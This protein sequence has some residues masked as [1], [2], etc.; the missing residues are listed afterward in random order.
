MDLGI[1]TV[2]YN[3]RD[4]LA[5]CLNS[6][7]VGLE[8]SGLE[9]ETWVVDNASS[10]GSA[11]MVRQCFP[12]VRIVAHDQNLGFAAG[13]NLALRMM[14]FG[15][16]GHPPD[17]ATPRHI[18]F[19]NPD[20][21]VIGDAL[22]VMVHFLD[23]SPRAGAAGAR[24]TYGDG[25]FQHS[26]FAF[27]GLAQVFF[28]FFPL[29][30]RLLESRLN[31]RYPRRQYEQGR[32]FPVDHPLGAALMVRGETLGLVGGFDESFF[33]YCEEIDLCRRIQSAGWDVYC[34]PEA[35]IV[36]LVGQSTRQFHDQMFVALWRSR[37]LMFDKYEG[38]M[39]GRAAR[40]L[41]RF[42]LWFEAR[43]AWA[44]HR[45]GGIDT[46]Q[47]QGRLAAYRKVATL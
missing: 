16:S 44:A 46:P 3:T 28:D 11:S 2:S 40:W 39:F 18:L 4:L 19:L 31:G 14:G 5:D 41:L 37:F 17:R 38:V 36:H 8:R 33:M 27:P 6:V 47:L 43:R 22:G 42:G 34:V 30:H 24:L 1:I 23:A 12:D 35:E 13:N 20:T 9:G 15:R 10:D 21:R 32:P 25:S 45:R 26:A 29:H 7:L